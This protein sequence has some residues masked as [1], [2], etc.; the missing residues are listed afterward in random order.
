MGGKP[1][2]QLWEDSEAAGSP[3]SPV[4]VLVLQNCHRTFSLMAVK[5]KE[6]KLK[7]NYCWS[8]M[9]EGGVGV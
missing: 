9:S 4:I 1:A 8:V 5:Y 3:E 2:P 7:L 6:K